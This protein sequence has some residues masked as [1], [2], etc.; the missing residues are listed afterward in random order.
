MDGLIILTS[1]AVDFVLVK[2]IHY[3][4]LRPGNS[5]SR[6]GLSDLVRVF[7]RD[8]FLVTFGCMLRQWSGLFCV[9]CLDVM[10][11]C[12]SRNL[13]V[14]RIINLIPDMTAYESQHL[15]RSKL[16]CNLL[17]MCAL[18]GLV[19]IRYGGSVGGTLVQNVRARCA[20]LAQ[21]RSRDAHALFCAASCCRMRLLF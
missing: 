8:E 15:P 21:V 17:G 7:N 5:R 20:H 16:L 1:S 18:L 14:K 12:L 2:F 6:V 3:Y 4:D 13:N 11:C 10:R 9:P 19:Q